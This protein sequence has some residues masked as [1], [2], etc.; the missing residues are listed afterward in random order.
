MKKRREEQKKFEEKV[1]NF[2][3]KTLGDEKANS[4]SLNLDINNI[5]LVGNTVFEEFQINS[6]LKKYIG[7]DK[8][9]YSLI[10]EIENKYIA[11][12]MLQQG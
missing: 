2:E 1:E 6:I 7:K 11:M 5:F 12:D 10:N 4:S 3:N 8:D 9:I